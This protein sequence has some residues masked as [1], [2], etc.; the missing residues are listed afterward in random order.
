MPT[1]PPTLD[2]AR[3]RLR[4]FRSDDAGAVHRH[5]AEWEVASTTAG[6]PH[7]YPP[8]AAEAWIAALPARHEAGEVV[9]LAVTRRD[10]GVL[11]GAVELRPGRGGHRAE[12]GYWTGRAHWHRGYAAEAAGALVEWGFGE[13]GLHRVH[14]GCMARNPASSAVLRRIGMRYEGTLRRHHLR[15]EVL[16]DVELYGRLATDGAEAS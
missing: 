15:W 8:G 7:P 4:P 5:L 1:H 16:E 3:L 10:D 9:A 11:V 14:A 6:V 12:L 2:T 13:M